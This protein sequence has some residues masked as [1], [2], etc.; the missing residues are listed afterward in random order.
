MVEWHCAQ[1]VP[2][3]T[4]VGIVLGVTR[5]AGGGQVLPPLARVTGHAGRGLVAAGQGK[6]GG[7]VVEARDDLL[8]PGGGVAGLARPA[9]LAAVRLLLCVARC[10]IAGGA[11]IVVRGAVA[12]GAIHLRVGA[13]D[14]VVGESVVEAD[15]AEVDQ[16]GLRALVFAVAA[17]AGPGPG[18]REAAV[19]VCAGGDVG[20]DALVAGRALAVLRFLAEMTSGSCRSWTQAA[21]AR[22]ST[23]RG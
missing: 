12:P 11:A 2:A 14:R 10:A 17:L 15:P 23:A 5:N 16:P 3:R 18:R 6:A 1:L 8:P 21:G 4:L 19:I 7:G 20:G 13:G 22:R 9:Q